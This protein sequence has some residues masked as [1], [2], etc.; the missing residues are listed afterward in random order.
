M[1]RPSGELFVE[2]GP[3][4]GRRMA[5]LQETVAIGRQA[6]LSLNDPTLSGH[7]ATLVWDKD[8]RGYR[9]RHVS[10]TNATLVNGQ[11]VT[12]V[13]LAHN[14][15]I[16]MGRVLLRYREA[17]RPI[18]SR[19]RRRF[20]MTAEVRI[21]FY[22]NLSV[23]LAC[24]VPMLRSLEALAGQAE[25][26]GWQ[27][28]LHDMLRQIGG[29]APLSA[30]MLAQVPR[31]RS[32]D[33][34]LVR[35]GEQSGTIAEV[36]RAAA[37][38]AQKDLELVRRVRSSLTYPAIVLVAGMG[39]VV[40]LGRV[41]FQALVPMLRDSGAPLPA[42]TRALMA[43]SAAVGSPI[44]DAGLLLLAAGAA[45][46]AHRTLS[47]PGG[48]QWWDARILRVPLVGPLLLKVS[49][50]RFCYSLAQLYRGGLP[51]SQAIQEASQAC[52]NVHL[53]SRL[54]EAT[55]R[56]RDGATLTE[57]LCQTA[58]LP[59]IML[60]L[61]DVGE[62]SGTLDVML[63]RAAAW[64]ETEVRDTL[65]RTVRA[66]EPLTLAAMGVLV[67]FILVAAFLPIYA[68]VSNL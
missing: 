63:A 4:R 13:L 39:M 43:V 11:P 50:A 66:L 38:T 31:F 24:G 8:R 27:A 57:A 60:S 48:R 51:L 67:G 58:T 56:L 15:T 62:N 36:L 19:R 32:A 34:A 47:T 55:W 16:R 46:T 65:E 35:A 1:T 49:A 52:G 68:T 20:R 54:Q 5:L 14:D 37:D 44:V 25:D 23:M 21:L 3:E 26:P 59:W 7:H 18:P 6:R 2:E 9:L 10:K 45:M 17:G 22:H 12:D 53:A 28:I 61:V 40:L 30:C 42:V 41:A 33:V 64:L 29:G